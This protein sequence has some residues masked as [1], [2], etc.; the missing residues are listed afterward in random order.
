MKIE[1]KQEA[2]KAAIYVRVST[3]EQAQF[4]YSI[5]AQKEKLLAFCKSQDWEV[6][7]TYADEGFSAKG[8]NRPQI[9][10][11]IDE[12]N[13]RK[14][15]IVVFYKLDRLSRSVKDLNFLIERFEENKVAIKSI[16]EP[17][18]TSSPP[19]KLMFNML[20]SFAQFERELI[21]ERT[22]LG[23]GRR[24][25]E[26]KWTTTPPF[27]YNMVSGDLVINEKEIAYYKRML[28]LFL[29]HNYGTNIIAMKLNEEDK[30]T[31]RA[32]K[33]SDSTVWNMLT[34]PVYCGLVRWG[35]SIFEG[36]HKAIITKEEFDTIQ[37][38]LHEKNNVN[39]RSHSSPNFL[40]G[41]ITC[42]ICNSTLTTAKGKKIY[43]YYACVGRHKG[44]K[45]NYVRTDELH[46]AVLSQ[47]YEVGKN[48]GIIQDHID[49]HN[50][51][52]SVVISRLEKELQFAKREIV[53]LIKKRDKKTAWLSENLPDRTVSSIIGQDIEEIA[54]QIKEL[55][56]KVNQ[57]EL[58]IEQEN[59]GKV[60]VEIIGDFLL[61]F[62]DMFDKLDIYQKRLLIQ[63]VVKKVTVYSKDRIKLD[64]ALPV[65]VQKPVAQVDIPELK[66]SDCYPF[67]QNWGG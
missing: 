40:N 33:W 28:E 51:S 48:P 13:Q 45:L 10:R 52:R 26:G 63:S 14:F 24:V 8:L 57:V 16:T 23:I 27:G 60:N 37:K 36:K 56:S 39:E 4:G 44:C 41:L 43:H 15:N 20:G 58:E 1:Q 65:N 47:I 17:F 7:N 5:D 6:Y 25:S 30:V 19:G 62:K 32:G 53:E 18:D 66:E 11:L 3:D 34:N 22:K 67:Y 61:H 38:R 64:L 21:G 46:K 42:G 35:D 31:R 59:L 12:A 49:E 55:N 29:Y 54:R 2:T 50:E 9:Q